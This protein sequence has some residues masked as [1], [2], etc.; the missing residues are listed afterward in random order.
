[1][2]DPTASELITRLFA[3][4]R[5]HEIYPYE[6]A[7]SQSLRR[8]FRSCLERFCRGEE[9]AEV[10]I[11]MYSDHFLVNN[12]LVKPDPA[13]L[14]HFTSLLFRFKQIK[15]KRLR[16][17]AHVPETE[18][19]LFVKAFIQDWSR[20]HAPDA[21]LTMGL[22]S[23]ACFAGGGDTEEVAAGKAYQADLSNFLDMLSKTIVTHQRVFR[24]VLQGGSADFLLIRRLVQ[25]F[26]TAALQMRARSLG[27]LPLGLLEKREAVHGVL[28]ALVAIPFGKSLG[29]SRVNQE[30]LVMACFFCA[31]GKERIA[32]ELVAEWGSLSKTEHEAFEWAAFQTFQVLLPLGVFS[33]SMALLL[34]T[35]AEMKF[36]QPAEHPFARIL[37]VVR[38]Y[39]AMVQHKPFR[40]ALHPTEAMN[41][42]WRDRG[43]SFNQ[44]TVEAFLEFLGPHPVGSTW[45]M[46]QGYPLVVMDPS[47]SA[48]YKEGKWYYFHAE[49]EKPWPLHTFPVNP[50]SAFLQ[51]G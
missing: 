14:S 21:I 26:I 15:L 51:W 5:T 32:L 47:L 31:I 23:V 42:L 46:K 28:R 2:S 20:R 4:I 50:M 10:M 19:I 12:R 38:A 6:N 36:Q 22:S 43:K 8:E 37:Q 1:M 39:E 11:E 13:S 33:P 7:T 29:L 34:N 44:E 16:L 30:E 9:A 17:N 45:T 25:E 24:Q 48:V 18:L 49:P 40:L 3:L 41:V 27:F 35:G